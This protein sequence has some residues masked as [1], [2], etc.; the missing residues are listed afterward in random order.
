[1]YMSMA[2]HQTCADAN[3]SALASSLAACA[4]FSC[5]DERQAVTSHL[6][7]NLLCLII[8]NVSRHL[9]NAAITDLRMVCTVFG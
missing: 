4:L 7:L 9:Q 3:N 1:M 5:N 2:Y 6:Q 8:L